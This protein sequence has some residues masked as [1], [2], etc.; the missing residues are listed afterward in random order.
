MFLQSPSV[1]NGLIKYPRIYPEQSYCGTDPATRVHSSCDRQLHSPQP[2]GQ[3]TGSGV[4]MTHGL[5][6]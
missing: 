1:Y 4:G 3:G 2:G 5:Q 6:V